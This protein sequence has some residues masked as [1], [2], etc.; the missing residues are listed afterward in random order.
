MDTSP[1]SDPEV[2]SAKRATDVNRNQNIR[3][4]SSIWRHTLSAGQWFKPIALR[5]PAVGVLRQPRRAR[6]SR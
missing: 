4:R 3:I 2:R 6:T 1:E 5:L